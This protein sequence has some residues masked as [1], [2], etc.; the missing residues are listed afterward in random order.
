MKAFDVKTTEND[1]SML[2]IAED[3]KQAIETL[4]EERI[5]DCDIVSITMLHYPNDH[6]KI[7]KEKAKA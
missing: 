4:N 1:Y 3:Y 2:V 6:I 7:A 5:Y